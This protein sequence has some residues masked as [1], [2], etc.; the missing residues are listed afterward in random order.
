M[1]AELVFYPQGL[2][3]CEDANQSS[4]MAMAVQQQQMQNQ[5]ELAMM[6]AAMTPGGSQASTGV[7]GGEHKMSGQTPCAK[8]PVTQSTI[9]IAAGGHKPMNMDDLVAGF[10]NVANLRER[11]EKWS[12]DISK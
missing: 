5:G 6:A 10:H 1:V 12:V 9:A 4:A 7:G 3:T 8:R 2:I 11:D